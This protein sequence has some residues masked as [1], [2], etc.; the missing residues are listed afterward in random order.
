MRV[1][2]R[3]FWMALSYRLG[4]LGVCL[5]YLLAALEI[6]LPISVF[7]H[8]DS[9]QPFPCQDHP[10]GCQTAEQCWSHCCCFTPEERWAWAKA[11]NVEP[12]AYAE[13]PV[14]KPAATGWNTVK[15]RDRAQ[16][17][18]AAKSC[19]QAKTEQASCCKPA[20]DRSAKAASSGSRSRE[21]TTLTVLRCQGYSTLWVSAGA[22]LPVAPNSSWQPD[23]T[24]PT[25]I[26]LFSVEADSVPSTPLDPP[27]RRSLV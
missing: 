24:P 3:R 9:S 2:T 12:P 27:P 19:C 13:M 8:K 26:A 23:W 20:A 4:V 18:T 5:A 14:E 15:L 16:N 17:Q 21:M 7:V 6:P 22:V 25:R 1:L 11:H 10:C